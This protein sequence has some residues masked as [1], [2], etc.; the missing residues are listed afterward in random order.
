MHRWG[1][2]PP[3]LAPHYIMLTHLRRHNGRIG[4]I[5]VMD[6]AHLALIV[7]VARFAIIGFANGKFVGIQSLFQV[8]DCYPYVSY[9]QQMNLQKQL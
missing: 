3:L 2:A 6:G 8:E 7:L 4:H 9:F 5:T 1:K